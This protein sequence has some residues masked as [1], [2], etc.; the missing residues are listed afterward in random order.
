MVGVEKQALIFVRQ[1]LKRSNLINRLA[2]RC[3]FYH[4][5]KI[6]LCYPISLPYI[7]KS[8]DVSD[9]TVSSGIKEEFGT[10]TVFPPKELLLHAEVPICRVC[11]NVF[12]N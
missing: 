12:H 11:E 2:H 6:R 4:T 7:I 10:K 9:G 1:Q 5:F 3:I 8:L